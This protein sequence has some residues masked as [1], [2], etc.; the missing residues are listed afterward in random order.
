MARSDRTEE[1]VGVVDDAG[2]PGSW[3]SAQS[4]P[5]WLRA[6]FGEVVIDA[7][8]CPWG[9]RNETWLAE[10]G[11]GRRFVATRLAD[12]R[13]AAVVPAR[14]RAVQPRLTA[15]G[16]PVQAL[17]EPGLPRARGVLISPF[18]DGVPGPVLLREPSGP[19]IVGSLLGSAWRRLAHADPAGLG[20]P[21]LWA[22]PDRLA[23]AARDWLAALAPELAR[24]DRARLAGTIETLPGLIDSRSAG[25][26]HGDLVPANILVDDGVL[27][28]LL[29]LEFVRLGDRRLDAAW[30]DW[31]VWFH[32]RP[33]HPVAW[34]AFAA[35]A[36]IQPG[37]A[38]TLEALRVLPAIRLL[39][40][41]HDLGRRDPAR[42]R[43]MEH[44]G[45][46]LAR[47]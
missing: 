35:A 5:P 38:P 6:A 43:W 44:L 36:G 46:W 27:V 4:V 1:A 34:Q 17:A 47:S 37:D 10:L 11:D 20:L 15:V 16:L 13:A 19:A 39:E 12:R 3:P 7:S 40:I 26:V 41:L 42:K 2:P 23:W 29:D 31:I 45:A 21:D 25:I 22:E 30:F 24:A 9:F 18:Q 14:I 33:I 8:R 32:H 28:A